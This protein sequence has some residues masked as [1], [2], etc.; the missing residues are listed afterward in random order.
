MQPL[1]LSRPIPLPVLKPGVGWYDDFISSSGKN[2]MYTVS[3]TGNISPSPNG[4]Y[5][6]RGTGTFTMAL[7]TYFLAKNF[8]AEMYMRR[9]TATNLIFAFRSA[10]QLNTTD[11]WL[12]RFNYNTND[13]FDLVKVVNN[14][15]TIV[16][17]KINVGGTIFHKINIRA[18]GSN[19]EVWLNDIKLFEVVSTEHIDN[20]YFYLST[21]TTINGDYS[22]IGYLV[23]KP[24]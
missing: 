24:L 16:G 6:I 18:I 2:S 3:N 12:I 1:I 11:R 14:T 4:I 17:Q 21:S 23:I 22:E 20:K 5:M 19:I 7:P 8:E 15:L 13:S 9:V 10:T